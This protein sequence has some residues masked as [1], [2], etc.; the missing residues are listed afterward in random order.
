MLSA[1]NTFAAVCLLNVGLRGH[2]SAMCSPHFTFTFSMDLP[3]LQFHL[4]LLTILHFLKECDY[5]IVNTHDSQSHLSKSDKK[6]CWALERVPPREVGG[7]I[8]KEIS[9]ECSR[10]FGLDNEVLELERKYALTSLNAK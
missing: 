8:C 9:K 1:S 5:L 3:M 4:N 6:P 7:K 2:H 10:G